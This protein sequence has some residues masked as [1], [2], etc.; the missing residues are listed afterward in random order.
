MDDGVLPTSVYLSE[1][2]IMN[3]TPISEQT[4]EQKIP[5][6]VEQASKP[7][8]SQKS[9]LQRKDVIK[10]YSFVAVLLL[11]FVAG[12]LFFLRPKVSESEKRTLTEFPTFTWSG[13]VSGDYFAQI[14]TWYSDTFPGREF[15]I[16]LNQKIKNL[17]GIRTVQIVQNPNV[18]GNNDPT[19]PSGPSGKD[20]ATPGND[21]DT[22]PVERFDRVYVKGNRA[23]EIYSFSASAS[24]RYV[25]IINSAAEKL[26]GAEVYNIIVP[27]SYS[28]NLTKKEQKSIGAS[29]VEEAISYMYGKMDSR[30]HTV[31]VLSG[32]LEHKEEYLYYRTDHHWTAR[33][34][35]YAYQAFCEASGQTA[36]PL[37]GWQKYEFEGFLGTLYS[38]AGKPSSL[39]A[40]PDTVEAWVPNS[41]NSMRTFLA[42][43]KSWTEDYPIVRRNTDA[44][45]ANAASKYNCF[46]A[47]DHP[48]IEIKNPNPASTNGKSI[49][50]VKESY[51]NAFVPFLVDQYETVY[52]VDY[53]YFKKATGKTLPEFVSEV[54]ADQVLFINYIY[55]T[56]EKARLDELQALLG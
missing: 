1:R 8:A 11:L 12:L 45:Y 22:T 16:S 2:Y 27:L 50:V 10:I 41:T 29:D 5:S 4:Q 31:E 32:L 15:F 54:G 33:G 53:R 25:S 24:D 18:P 51:G 26:N 14:G 48:L 43:S 21:G 47:G 39:S 55:A 46:I 40:T 34:A 56:S 49:V 7:G 3:Q 28:V 35:Y 37:D 38:S 19:N 52:V 9:Q 13:F 23:F 44:Y 42:Q 6:P 20:P 17:Y 30:V 36:L